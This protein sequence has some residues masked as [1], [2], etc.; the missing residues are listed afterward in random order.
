M[1][2]PHVGLVEVIRH[3]LPAI[4]L[5]RPTRLADLGP[6]LPA[7]VDLPPADPADHAAR[8]RL[9]GAI[10]QAER[11]LGAPGPK[12][13]ATSALDTAARDVLTAPD[14]HDAYFRVVRLP[15]GGLPEFRRGV[16]QAL[17]LWCDECG[18][19]HDAEAAASVGE[20]LRGLWRVGLDGAPAVATPAAPAAAAPTPT[21]PSERKAAMPAERAV[22]RWLR[23]HQIFAVI[24]Q[25]LILVVQALASAARHGDAGRVEAQVLALAHLYRASAAAFRFTADFPRSHYEQLIRP[26]MSEPHAPAGFSG[27]LSPDHACLVRALMAAQPAFDAAA[28]SCPAALAEAREALAAMYADHKLVCAR[29]AGLEQPSIRSAALTADRQ[30]SGDLLDRFH[31]RR[32]QLLR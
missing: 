16:L 20:A 27:T 31:E 21:R 14:P 28:R 24:T 32:S 2:S 18:D 22:L 11:S 8:V 6:A 12:A 13:F 30:A 26:S 1:T 23:G 15:E 10:A 4:Q 17:S 7:R 25:G 9:R 29:L 19:L 3:Q 5:I